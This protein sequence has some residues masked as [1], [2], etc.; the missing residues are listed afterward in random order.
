MAKEP[1]RELKEGD[2]VSLVKTPEDLVFAAEHLP[3]GSFPFKD[4]IRRIKKI[5]TSSKG[6]CRY[7]VVLEDIEEDAGKKAQ[8][9]E[10]RL[11]FETDAPKYL[12][13]EI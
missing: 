3:K 13:L 1:Q 2:I 5:T 11:E 6:Y 8:D 12:H 7:S 10:L 9:Y 4:E